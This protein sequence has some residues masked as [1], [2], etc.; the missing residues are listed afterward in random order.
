[1]LV[2]NNQPSI[3]LCVSFKF[4]SGSWV[5]NIIVKQVLL[6]FN[7]RTT[8]DEELVKLDIIFIR[9]IIYQ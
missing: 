9:E 8:F 1:M 6:Y 4:I 3:G 5:L 7:A 2:R